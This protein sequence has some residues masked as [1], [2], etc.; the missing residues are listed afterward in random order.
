MDSGGADIYCDPCYKDAIGETVADKEKEENQK[1][2]DMLSK[3][4]ELKRNNSKIR[5]ITDLNLGENG[6]I[7]GFVSSV[8]SIK[9]FKKNDK[10]RK[11]A[12]FRIKDETGEIQVVLYEDKIAGV[13]YGE[14]YHIKGFVKEFNGIKQIT[15]GFN[16][17]ITKLTL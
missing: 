17:A 6:E 8:I 16:G 5:S 4:K 15:L 1:Q 7:V 11:L 2:K 10:L 9:E 13:F 3:I 12:E 14:P